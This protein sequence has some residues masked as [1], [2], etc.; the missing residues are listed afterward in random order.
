MDKEKPGR[1]LCGQRT[2]NISCLTTMT[3][4]MFVARQECE[5]FNPNSTIP[6]VKHGG[7]SIMLW[8][9]FGAS[10]SGALK[11]AK[12]LLK[13]DIF[14]PNS[15]AKDWVVCAFGC[16]NWTMIPNTHQK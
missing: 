2:H 12:L 11:K 16:S 13:K 14:F 5:A 10:G 9:C 6:A 15:S 7:G 4:T 3:R 1:K 8:G